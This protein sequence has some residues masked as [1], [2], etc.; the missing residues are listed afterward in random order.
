MKVIDAGQRVDAGGLRTLEGAT[1][2]AVCCCHLTVGLVCGIFRWSEVA[3]SGRMNAWP[4]VGEP[5][6]A[7][8]PMEIFITVCA[9]VLTV[10]GLGFYTVRK[11]NPVLF[12]LHT[13]L[14]RVFCFG[15][16]IR[17]AAPARA[18]S[19]AELEVEDETKP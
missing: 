8:S 5:P 18:E 19:I 4:P 13:S 15:I 1:V 11:M 6:G 3:P 16:E 12:R 10:I 2:A 7:C 17:A 14:W 9:V